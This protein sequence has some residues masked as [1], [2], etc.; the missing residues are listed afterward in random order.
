MNTRTIVLTASVIFNKTF[1]E[2]NDLKPT[3]DLFLS[4]TL[5]PLTTYEREIYK[6]NDG[7]N[8]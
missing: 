1:Y 6:R 4:I 7:V 3:E 8:E 2:D 5:I